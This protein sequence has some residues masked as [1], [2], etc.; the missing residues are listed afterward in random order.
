MIIPFFPYDPEN[1]K[2]SVL[3]NEDIIHRRTVK[4]ID[5]GYN[6]GM[7]V[8]TLFQIPPLG[9][10]KEVFLNLHWDNWISNLEIALEYFEGIEDY[11]MCS[12]SKDVLDRISE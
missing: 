1:P 9:D 10:E 3:E 7:D 2:N 4:M 11:E 5:I 8:V 12:Y 6:N